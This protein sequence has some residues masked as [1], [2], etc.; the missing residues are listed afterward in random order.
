MK[1]CT[2]ESVLSEMTICP[3]LFAPID[4][5]IFGII[6]FG[7]ILMASAIHWQISQKNSAWAIRTENK[8][9]SS[10][11]DGKLVMKASIAAP[12][13]GWKGNKLFRKPLQVAW[14]YS[15]FDSSSLSLTLPLSLCSLAFS[16]S[17]VPCQ[18]LLTQCFQLVHLKLTCQGYYSLRQTHEWH[19]SLCST[20]CPLSVSFHCIGES[21][22]ESVLQ[23]CSSWQT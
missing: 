5:G 20:P 8:Q 7:T 2:S 12:R 18:L 21:H 4:E 15:S 3:L 19:D 10:K 23:P 17:N 13:P 16:S 11:S 9:S 22:R 1:W 6:S 14:A